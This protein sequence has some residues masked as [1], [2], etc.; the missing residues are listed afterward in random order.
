[1]ALLQSQEWHFYHNAAWVVTARGKMIAKHLRNCLDNLPFRPATQIHLRAV[2]GICCPWDFLSLG[3]AV[4]AICC[5][6][7]LHVGFKGDEFQSRRKKPGVTELYPKPSQNPLPCAWPGAQTHIC[8]HSVRSL[9]HFKVWVHN[10]EFH[11]L[12]HIQLK[13]PIIE[14]KNPKTW[15]LRSWFLWELHF[16]RDPLSIWGNNGTS[17]P[18]PQPAPLSSS[19]QFSFLC[20]WD[21]LKQP[22]KHWRTREQRIYF[23]NVSAPTHGLVCSWIHQGYPRAWQTK[24]NPKTKPC[25][26]LSRLQGSFKPLKGLCQWWETPVNPNSKKCPLEGVV[27]ILLFFIILFLVIITFKILQHLISKTIHNLIP[28]TSIINHIKIQTL[29]QSNSPTN[30]K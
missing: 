30:Y 28:S 10:P 4:P 12:P 22:G 21:A 3:F 2:P 1:M 25:Y 15:L 29:K 27:T 9:W 14:H 20:A 13:N 17:G 7:P 18:L 6:C 5:P 16:C 23:W 24:S 8:H 19:Q 11:A 26:S